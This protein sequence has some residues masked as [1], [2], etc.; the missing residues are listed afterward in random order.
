MTSSVHENDTGTPNKDTLF[1]LASLTKLPTTVAVLQIVERGIIALDDDVGRILP[2]LCQHGVLTGFTHDGHPI[3]RPRRNPITVRQL[4]THSA[5][6]GY[7]F[8]DPALARFQQSGGVPLSSGSTV[9]ERFDHPLLFE[10]GKSWNYGCSIDWAGLLVE[11]LL[12]TDL[13]TYTKENIWKPLGVS[14]FTFWPDKP[15][16]AR[17]QRVAPMYERIANSG[18]LKLL[19]DGL[20]LNR[21]LKNCFGGQ[22]GYASLDDFVELLSSLL[23]DDERILK[24]ETTALMFRPQLSTES[25]TTLQTKMADPSWAIGDFYDGEEYD[26]GLGGLLVTR[27]SNG[28][29]QPGT[30]IWSGIANLFWVRRSI[31]CVHSEAL[32]TSKLVHRSSCR[33]LRRLHD[34]SSPCC[35]SRD[36]RLATCFSE[37]PL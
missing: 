10:P 15:A 32:L 3:L 26:W 24:K 37:R 34:A 30:L 7:D 21:G 28:H 20:E 36:P 6:T 18:K 35:R 17:P 8:S 4:L 12:S 29:R 31:S 14:S 11:K 2:E 16:E 1:A 19:P 5:G 22:G 25:A 23:W 27:G 33:A 13:E 9:E